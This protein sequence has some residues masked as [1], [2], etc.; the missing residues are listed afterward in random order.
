MWFSKR[1]TAANFQSFVITHTLNVLDCG[2]LNPVISYVANDVSEGPVALSVTKMKIT[3]S[4]AVL[5]DS[6]ESV[7]T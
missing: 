1:F 3:G 2:Q 6:D 7:L 4:S 5:I